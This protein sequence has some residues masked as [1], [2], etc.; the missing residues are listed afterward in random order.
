[1]KKKKEKIPKIKIIG[2]ILILFFIVS[3]KFY[4]RDLY[5][6]KFINKTNKETYQGLINLWDSPKRSIK[7]SEYGFINNCISNFTK[8][9]ELLQI[10]VRELSFEGSSV[11]AKEKALSKNH[12]DIISKYV[13]DETIPRNNIMYDKDFVSNIKKEY[14]VLKITN[15]EQRCIF[16]LYGSFNVIIINK[17]AFENMQIDIPNSDWSYSTFIN[18]IK[19]IK[20][21]DKNKTKIPF[22]MVVGKNSFS[23]MNFIMDEGYENIDYEKLKTLKNELKGYNCLS[24]KKDEDSVKYDLYNSK[25]L[26]YAG[27]MND[28]N[29]LIRNKDRE[30]SFEYLVYPYPYEESKV[31]FMCDVKSYYILNTVDTPKKQ[32]LQNFIEHM[33]K[34]EGENILNIQ[35]KIPMFSV[36]YDEK[37]L[38]Y[39]YLKDYINLEDYYSTEDE[40]FNLNRQ[41]IY[42]NIK[43]ILK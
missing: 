14:N 17:T 35:G 31:N 7:G 39:P 36:N 20:N 38:K 16:P 10:K 27:N 42:K 29:Y 19:Q 15:E 8:E 9:N 26:I 3:Y 43:Q 40:E 4:I 32:I 22:D 13:E 12:P 25:T 37:N 2:C 28:V 24:I 30:N 1:M 5:I 18:T 11:L 33:Y 6:Q 34:N 41:N 21:K 23:Y